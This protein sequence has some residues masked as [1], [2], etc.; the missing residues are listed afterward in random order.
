MHNP[1]FTVT[2]SSQPDLS[3]NFFE[4]ASRDKLQTIPSKN[5]TTR[6]FVAGMPATSSPNYERYQNRETSPQQYFDAREELLD[7]D[8]DGHINNEDDID[9]DADA[10]ADLSDDDE[11][12][13]SESDI[14]KELKAKAKIIRSEAYR[15]WVSVVSFFD[16]RRILLLRSELTRIEKA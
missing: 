7:S 10:D 5:S 13:P 9:A 16:F 3:A 8:A 12:G 15:K 11:E 1:H 6:T 14:L 4:V 2:D